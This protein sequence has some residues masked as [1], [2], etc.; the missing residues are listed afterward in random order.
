[1]WGIF[2]GVGTCDEFTLRLG[3]HKNILYMPGN[4]GITMFDGKKSKEITKSY[5]EGGEVMQGIHPTT[6][7]SFGDNFLVTMLKV[8]DTK[9]LTVGLFKPVY[10]TIGIISEK[11]LQAP[12]NFELM[13]MMSLPKIS[14][15]IMRHGTIAAYNNKFVIADPLFN[16]LFMYT[17]NSN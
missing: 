12:S 8:K 9:Y 11:N 15:P 1:M 16:Q 13:Y 10:N 5:I 4:R 7:F 17:V 6:K 3:V 2:E 14:I